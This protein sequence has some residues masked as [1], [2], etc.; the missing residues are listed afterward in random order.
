MEHFSATETK[1]DKIYSDKPFDDRPCWLL[2]NNS[3]LLPTAGRGLDLACGLGGNAL[4][5]ARHGLESHAWDASSVALEKL[6]A[7]ANSNALSVTTL[8]RDIEQQP[9]E[10]NSFDVITVSHFLYRPL[11][12]YLLSALR[13]NG[14]LFYQTFNTNKPSA[15]GPSNPNFL[16]EENE[17]LKIFSSMQLLFY[18]EDGLT[19]DLSAGLRNC[20]YFIGKNVRQK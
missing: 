9:P 7:R 2:E 12:P 18:R 16:L 10:E 8:Q 19:G 17:L 20:S 1:W 15:V 11:M 6:S 13:P 5:L 3:H 4:H 14:I